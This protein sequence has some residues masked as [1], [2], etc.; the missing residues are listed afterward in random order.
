ML[1]DLRESVPYEQDV[2]IVAFLYRDAYH[3]KEQAT[4]K[5]QVM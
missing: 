5:K 2:D 3:Q 4:V 1:A